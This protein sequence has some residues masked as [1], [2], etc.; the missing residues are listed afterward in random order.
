MDMNN[1]EQSG[2][3]SILSLVMGMFSVNTHYFLLSLTLEFF[4]FSIIC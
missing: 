4:V 2:V 1:A 3:R